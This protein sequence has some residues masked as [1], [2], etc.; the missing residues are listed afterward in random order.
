MGTTPTTA[1][2][3]E[4]RQRIVTA[5]VE[6]V[7]ECGAVS[8][9]LDAVGER[10]PASRSQLYHYFDDKSDLLRAVAEA[11]NDAV[12]DAQEELFAG[13]DRWEGWVRWADALVALQEARGGVGGCPIAN[14]LGQIGE[15]DDDIRRVLATGFDRWESAIHAGLRHMVD[16]GELRADADLD[17]L[18]VSTLASLQGGLVLAQARRDPR[19]LRAALDGALTLIANSRTAH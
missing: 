1:R 4:T 3:R 7:A 18:A 11:T 19:A 5:A 13:L 6:V 10:A 15:R 14:L 2:G 12:M 9:S 17:Q 8:A 16:S